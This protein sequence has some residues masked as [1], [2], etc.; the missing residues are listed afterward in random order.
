MFNSSELE[1]EVDHS[2]FDSDG[3]D[4]NVSRGRG[5]KMDSPPAD[6]RLRGKRT[7]KKKEDLSPRM[8]G[9]K[10]HLEQVNNRSREERKERCYHSKQEE[11]RRASN[12]TSISSTS[13]KGISSSSD[14]EE[15]YHLRS[16]R[17][18]KTFMA[19]LVETR[20]VHEEDEY[21]LSPNETEE[22]ALPS[23]AKH[24]KMRNKQSPKK[25]TRNWRTRS[26]SP[27]STE[28]DSDKC[29]SSGGLVSPTL[30]KPTKSSLFPTERRARLGSAGS[31]DSPTSRT[32]ESDDT[33]TDVSPLSSPDISP[34]QSL[35][36]N[37]TQ[38]D[39]GSFKEQQQ[40]QEQ[41]EQESVPS[42]GLSYIHPDENSDQ[43]VDESSLGSESQFGFKQVVNFPGRKNRKNFS[44]SNNEVRRIDLENQRLLR[45][46][47]RLSA[48][49]IPES[50]VKKKNNK[51]TG[52]SSAIRLTHSAVNRQREQ[53]RIERENLAFLK[54]LESVKP[55][56]GMRRSEQLADY[57][58][59]ATHFGAPI[60]PVS[61]S[62]SK[63]VRWTDSSSRSVSSTHH[64]SRAASTTTTE[65][66][67]SPGPRSKQLGAAA[68]KHVAGYL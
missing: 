52:N 42:S 57:H 35:D 3:D 18:D 28:A 45:S 54:R 32:E 67:S 64:S 17:P 39:E 7:E 37:H 27:T 24:T 16:K 55:S 63:K 38:A 8:D 48:E 10:K 46:L 19:L 33:V 44:F 60:Y 62:T 6:E 26:P 9:T 56:N 40:Q 53:K 59:R 12:R 51:E 2:F 25:L 31:R 34:L 20:D 23:T 61:Q 15:D 21:S 49:S 5:E 4:V 66:S 13:D 30:P 41:Q 68:K 36:L 43:E 47:S 65:S 1:G 22:E 14:S 50:A 58:R 11:R 29:S